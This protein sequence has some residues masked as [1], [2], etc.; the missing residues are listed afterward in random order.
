MRSLFR[1]LPLSSGFS[2]KEFVK[3]S[4]LLWP[5]VLSI[6][7]KFSAKMV[8]PWRSVG[9]TGDAF[10]VLLLKALWHLVFKMPGTRDCWETRRGDAKRFRSC[11]LTPQLP[12]LYLCQC[13]PS[14]TQFCQRKQ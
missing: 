10:Y 12:S 13:L 1:L 14:V 2:E 4:D 8:V 7:S 9:C 5:L 3:K 6:S 11:F